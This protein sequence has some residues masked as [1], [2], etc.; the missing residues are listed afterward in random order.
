M[1]TSHISGGVRW[2]VPGGGPPGLTASTSRPPSCVIAALTNASGS[3]GLDTS[4]ASQPAAL[5]CFA[6][7]S[8]ETG[9][10]EEM[11]TSAPSPISASAQARPNPLLAAATRAL[12][13]FNP[14]SIRLCLLVRVD[15][16]LGPMLE[17]IPSLHDA[18]HVH[19]VHALGERVL[20]VRRGEK[21]RR[22]RIRHLGLDVKING[23]SSGLI[24]CGSP[25]P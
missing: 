2:K 11:K 22:R 15:V 3:V 1:A 25:L 12:R 24:D 14:R 21:D 9:S 6:V 10:R 7:P 13:P 4:D 8:I 17:T 5:I 20:V 16:H 19:A 18:L 23:Q